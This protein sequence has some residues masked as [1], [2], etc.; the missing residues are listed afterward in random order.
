MFPFWRYLQEVNVKWTIALYVGILATS[1][2]GFSCAQKQAQDKA[3]TTPSAR[4]SGREVEKSV[5]VKP[6][7]RS[8]DSMA[9]PR[10]F[11]AEIV[12]REGA[13]LSARALTRIYY[14]YAMGSIIYAGEPEVTTTRY[15]SLE[16]ETDT[17]D[18]T[19]PFEIIRTV[20]FEQRYRSD[21]RMDGTYVIVSL[22]DGSVVEGW[23]WSDMFECDTDPGKTEI[24]AMNLETL[25]F[26][27][28]AEVAW[29]FRPHGRRQLVI[30][31][32]NGGEIV[33]EGVELLKNR[34][35]R[36]FCFLG[37]DYAPA[38]NIESGGA[39]YGI[40]LNKIVAITAKTVERGHVN[41]VLRDSQ[42]IEGFPAGPPV[43][44]VSQIVGAI[45]FRH[46]KLRAV[47]YLWDLWDR[48]CSKLEFRD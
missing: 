18:V 37:N 46:Y 32:R 45:A 15:A 40:P 6:A 28:K 26:S 1:I 34:H 25:T 31:S 33:L 14:S 38:L 7:S 35:N 27:H 12:T 19:V 3:Q 20:R 23:T 44:E 17:V 43:N 21:G 41:L 47:A 36:N 8:S 16:I 29:A 13:K 2:A 42:T 11:S 5:T 10:S 30:H 9:S 39:K 48:S 24:K 22:G 4:T